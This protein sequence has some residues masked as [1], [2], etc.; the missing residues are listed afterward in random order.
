MAL[1]LIFQHYSENSIKADRK[2]LIHNIK[3]QKKKKKYFSFSFP[4]SIFQEVFPNSL[5]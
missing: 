1:I 2:Y 3:A 5:T 4:Y